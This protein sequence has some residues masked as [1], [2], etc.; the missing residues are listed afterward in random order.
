[1]FII[2]ETPDYK[3]SSFYEEILN[4]FEKI[5]YIESKKDKILENSEPYKYQ[6]ITSGKA[7]NI[8]CPI[9]NYHSGSY[10]LEKEA[11]ENFSLFSKKIIDYYL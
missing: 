6:K 9:Y 11:L 5:S 2:K 3:L 8:L 10:F 1:M 7:I 4:S